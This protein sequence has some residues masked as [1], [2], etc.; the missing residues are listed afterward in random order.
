MYTEEGNTECQG[1]Q[2]KGYMA[3]HEKEVKNKRKGGKMNKNELPLY[4]QNAAP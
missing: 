4:N 2:M 1:T 3:L